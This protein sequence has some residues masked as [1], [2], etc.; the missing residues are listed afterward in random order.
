MGDGIE[1]SR[2]QS[3]L[4]LEAHHRRASLE[5]SAEEL[6]VLA[7]GKLFAWLAQQE[8]EVTVFSKAGAAAE[9]QV[10]EQADHADHG[11]WWNVPLAGLVVEAHVA[12]DHGEPERP[13]GVG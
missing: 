7:A 4:H 9:R 10:V 1:Q 3:T 12:A 8:D 6:E 5:P 11:R 2:L 13:A